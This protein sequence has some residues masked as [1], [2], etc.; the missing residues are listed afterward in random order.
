MYNYACTCSLYTC[1]YTFVF[2]IL[3]AAHMAGE[4]EVPIDIAGRTYIIDFGAM[5]QV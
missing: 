5:Q 1:T 2:V 3:Q 4:D